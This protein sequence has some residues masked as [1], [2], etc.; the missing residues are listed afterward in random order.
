[1]E[2]LPQTDPWN[3]PSRFPAPN[4]RQAIH[5]GPLHEFGQGSPVWGPAYWITAAQTVVLLHR[6]CGGPPGSFT[7]VGAALAA[8]LSCASPFWIL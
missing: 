1:M 3:F 5:Y 7:T 8:G 2:H 4:Q 6:R